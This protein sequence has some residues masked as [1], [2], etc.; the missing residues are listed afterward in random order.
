MEN[1]NV[2]CHD[3]DALKRIF[4]DLKDFLAIQGRKK[5]RSAFGKGYAAAIEEI[6]MIV[7]APLPMEETKLDDVRREDHEDRLPL[8]ILRQS[9]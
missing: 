7:G 9:A 2:E 3:C 1:Q 8:R 4:K 5:R 6:R